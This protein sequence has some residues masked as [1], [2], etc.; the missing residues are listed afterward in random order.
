MM[1]IEELL[2]R[3][4][5]V[6]LKWVEPWPGQQA[7][8][9]PAQADVELRAT[10]SHCIL[11]QRQAGSSKGDDLEV[12]G[13]FIAVHWATPVEPST[14]APDLIAKGKPF[15]RPADE[16]LFWLYTDNGDGE[17]WHLCTIKMVPQGNVMKRMLCYV[18]ENFEDYWYDED[19][20][21]EEIVEISPPPQPPS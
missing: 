14:P 7:S 12:L 17:R 19:W 3:R 8:G 21:P 15:K 1:S 18:T 9:A 5:E 2:K 10:V 4:D 6:N 13:D 11:I 16:T 20:C